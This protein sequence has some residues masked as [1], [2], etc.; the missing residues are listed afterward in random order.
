ML[1]FIGA[2]EIKL[3]VYQ[4]NR[5]KIAGK[6]TENQS[7]VKLLFAICP[8]KTQS[9]KIVLVPIENTNISYQSAITGQRNT[10]IG[11]FEE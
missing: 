2:I 6:L 11:S 10:L 9:S 8:I 4:K 1:M 3:S 7:R 5:L